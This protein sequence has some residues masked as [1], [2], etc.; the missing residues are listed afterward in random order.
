MELQHDDINDQ[1]QALLNKRLIATTQHLKHYAILLY[2]FDGQFYRPK[3]TG[4]FLS[5]KA[6]NFILTATH[7]INDYSPLYTNISQGI[8]PVREFRNLRGVL[9]MSKNK[10]VD[11]GWITLTVNFARELAEH[12]A[13]VTI[14][15]I[16]NHDPSK[17]DLKIPPYVFFGFS[18]S[19]NTI[20]EDPKA[21]IKFDLTAINVDKIR[22][23]N[24]VFEYLG[25]DP[26]ANL[27]FALLGKSQELIT[28]KTKFKLP[29]LNGM[30]GSGIWWL[31]YNPNEKELKL[32]YK[33]IGIFS[34]YRNGK[35]HCAIGSK[36]NIVLENI[37][38][39][40]EKGHFDL[41]EDEMWLNWSGNIDNKK[42]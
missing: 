1:L 38:L 27:A 13:F 28:G 24:A 7:V 21:K 39:W 4:V 5:Y 16:A 32:S 25:L 6:M 36:I 14:E 11:F 29:E 3:G 30:S 37:D 40:I 8:V 20:V 10:N 33:L 26:F 22:N 17:Y 23:K 9:D 15:D 35:Y 31:F 19:R 34:D 42:M 18:A 12:S 41:S 2:T